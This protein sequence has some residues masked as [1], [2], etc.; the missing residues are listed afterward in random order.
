MHKPLE[1]FKVV[2]LATYVAVPSA[3]RVMADWGAE[4]IKIETP[5]G[6]GWRNT[7]RTTRLPIRV[8]CNP[9]FT[10]DNSGKKLISLDLKTPE[11]KEIL[12]RLLAD[13]D[14]FMSSVRYGGLTRLGLDYDTLHEKYPRL[15]YAHFNGYGYEGPDGGNPGFDHSA[16]WGRSGAFHEVRD[17]EGRPTIAPGGFGDSASANAL[18]GGIIAALFN[19]TRTGEGMRIASSLYANS[20]WCNYHRIIAA[21]DRP[22]GSKP[23]YGPFPVRNR[24]N[25]FGHPYKCKDDTWFLMLGGNNAKFART[26]TAM[27]LEEYAEDERFNTIPAMEENADLLYDIM[28]AKFLEKTAREWAEVFR[29]LDI[30]SQVIA[31]SCDVSKDEQAWANDYIAMMDC[32]DGTQWVMPNSPVTFHGIEKT[33]TKH[34]GARGSDNEEVLKKYGYSEEQIKEL[35]AKGAVSADR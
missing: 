24:K 11:G 21:Q 6:D 20:T 16:F 3:A 15:V 31:G 32:P 4:V 9:I 13:A 25:P 18:V 8:D 35:Y 27:G 34:V 22:D 10:R 26:M 28:E 12:H 29:P 30:S 14:V 2:E 7:G 19:R 1:G 17:P 33:H 23:F 5:T